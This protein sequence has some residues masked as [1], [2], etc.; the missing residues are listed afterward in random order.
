M[1]NIYFPLI[2]FFG[3]LLIIRTTSAD[4]WAQDAKS[5]FPKMHQAYNGLTDISIQVTYQVYSDQNSKT[6][7]QTQDGVVRRKGDMLYTKIGGSESIQTKDFIFYANHFEK[8]IMIDKNRNGDP[9]HHPFMENSETILSLSKSIEYKKVN[10]QVALYFI[11]FS[12]SE[13]ESMEV[14]FNAH[15]FIISKVVFVYKMKNPEGGHPKLEI[16]YHHYNLK[17]KNDKNIFDYK[18][19]LV[20]KNQTLVCHDKFKDYKLINTY[21]KN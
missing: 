9:T 4:T 16:K 14:E 18:N 10:A 5:D 2:Y 1:K 15:T 11:T 7:L 20:E 21:L 17:A 19:F 3:L 13:Y 12:S 8:T 6:P